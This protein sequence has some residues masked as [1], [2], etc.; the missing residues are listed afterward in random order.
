MKCG[1]K[2]VHMAQ[3]DLIL[4]LDGAMD[5]FSTPPDPQRAIKIKQM[6]KKSQ[7]LV[8]VALG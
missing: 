4:K 8:G 5:H 2:L 6:S 7:K 1:L 3:Y